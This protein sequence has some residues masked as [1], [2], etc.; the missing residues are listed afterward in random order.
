MSA[1]AAHVRGLR[2]QFDGKIVLDGVDL[3]AD[4]GARLGIIGP[5]AGGKT[6][7]L[8][9]LCGL[10]E[11]DAGEIRLGDH[12]ITEL[13]EVGLM[14]AR[15]GV[16]MLFQNY[17]LYDFMTVRENVAFP[18]VRLGGLDADEIESRVAARLKR[19]G[20]SGS[21]DKMPSELSGGMKKRVG[22]ARATVA[23]PAIVIYDE[24]TAGLDPVTTQKIYDLITAD[25]DET[26][27]TVIAVSSDVG[28]LAGFS[29]KIAMLYD[30]V[31]RYAGDAKTIAESDDELVR[32]FV[33]GSLEGPLP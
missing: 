30:G 19:V 24:P 4:A 26:D 16:G 6:V 25:Q 17:A 21:E 23:K 7:L 20:L 9:L 22:I 11:A 32:Q 33:S 13:D 14:A 5:A 2:K 8:K 12:V 18:L 27:C 10:I 29:H 15:S 28:A 1:P 31:V 3:D